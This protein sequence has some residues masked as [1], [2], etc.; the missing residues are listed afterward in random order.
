MADKLPYPDMAD[1][2][3]KRD[4]HG[5]A[6]VPTTVLRWIQRRDYPDE[7]QYRVLQQFW[8]THVINNASTLVNVHNPGYNQWRDVPLVED[9]DEATLPGEKHEDEVRPG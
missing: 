9:P 6:W 2:I 1:V 5:V 4:F 7:H 3:R 8:E